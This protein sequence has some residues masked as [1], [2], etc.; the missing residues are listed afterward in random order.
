M[1]KQLRKL[2][3]LSLVSMFLIPA[4]SFA[5]I[6]D[7]R[8]IEADP[9]S[10][11]EAIAPRLTGLGN[12]SVAV[13]T[14]SEDSQ[15]F[16]NQGLRLTY[17]FNH[18]EALR[19][20]KEAIRL[21]PDNAMAYWGWALVLG[22]NL[23][24][25]MQA[26]VAEQAF[27]AIQRAMLLRDKV[28]AGEQAFIEALA[29]RYAPVA[30][31]D[32]SSLD[33]AYAAAMKKLTQTYPDDLDAATLYAA[34]LLNLSPWNYWFKDGT[35][36][37]QT[38]E[39]IAVLA[40]VVERNPNHPGALHYH[41]HAVEAVHPRQGESSANALQPLMP[42]AGHMVHMPSHIYMR[43]GRYADA[44]AANRQA[45]DADSEYI[46]Q[47]NAQGIYP[48]NYYPH[49]LHFLVWAAMF[50]GRSEAALAGAREVQ[51]KIPVDMQG[52]AFGAFET[53]L[54][55]P[56][57]VMVRFAMWD[58]ALSEP[59]PAAGNKFMQGVWH[60]ARGMAFSNTGKE[61]Q[62]KQE[63]RALQTLRDALAPDYLIGFGTA[64]KLLTIAELL[65]AADVA[66]KAED[67]ELALNR[68]GRAVRVEDSLLYNEPPD[69]YFPTR[70]NFGA[71][72]LQAGYPEE[73]AVIYW[74]DL[75]KNPA[76]GFSLMGLH[77]AQTAMG[78]ETSAASTKAEFEASWQA[79]D[80]KLSSSRF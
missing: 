35:P 8:A 52:N 46:T 45:S 51:S 54:A 11:T 23:N 76:N 24:L 44:F 53:F 70:H 62:A 18:S 67:Y 10:A 69:W 72:L 14:V 38:E 71:T 50:Q 74:E 13:T 37:A 58:K 15:Y 6:H 43:V 49:N 7:P 19:S 61:R 12:H 73:A 16:F 5:M 80:V 47:C 48:L 56:L 32:R 1:F 60:Y 41:I 3:A 57:Y 27:D 77:Q 65:L 42:G 79:A 78:D 34:A 4:A 59:E 40:S 21:D 75:R 25:P 29:T 64:P 20:F 28:S 55:Q 9:S 36:H 66:T 22:P 63:L 31:V 17:G 39:L 30:P 26:A 68:L 2:I 33:Q